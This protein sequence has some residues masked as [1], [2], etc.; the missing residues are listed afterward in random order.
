MALK[1][2][3]S[4]FRSISRPSLLGNSTYSSIA[5]KTQA[6]E[7]AIVDNQYAAGDLSSEYYLSQLKTRLSRGGLTPL[8]Q[9]ALNKKIGDVQV[10][11]N[12]AIM[13]N[14]YAGGKITTKDMYD[15]EKQKL[16]DMTEPTSTAYIQQQQKV[17]GLQ[18]KI[19]KES[20]TQFR[21]AENLRI[22]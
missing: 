19:E 7:D 5:K 10:A 9:V 21:I 22:S 2:L 6:A 17:Q 13:S 20:R 15:Y 8:Q 4:R 1:D 11:V 3:L 18:D 14:N 16:D 12:D